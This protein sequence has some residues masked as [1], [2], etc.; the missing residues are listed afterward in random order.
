SDHY[1]VEV[2]D[3]GSGIPEE[4]KSKIFGKFSQADSSDTRKAGGTGLGLSIAKAIVEKHGGEIDFTSSPN[5]GTCFFFHLPHHKPHPL[6]EQ[7]NGDDCQFRILI[8]E[9]NRDISKLLELM[10]Q[11][12]G[13]CTDTAFTAAEAEQ[14]VISEHYDAMTL[15]LDLPDK[16]GLQLLQE[17]RSRAECCD[18]PII[19]VSANAHQ[20]ELEVNGELLGVVDWHNKPIDQ[21]RLSVELKLA[22]TNSSHHTN[23]ILHVEDDPDIRDVVAA[24]ISN[25][26]EVTPVETLSRAK[27]RVRSELYDLII[28]DL[29]L[30]DGAGEDLI[31]FTKETLN[32]E[33]PVIV[34]SASELSSEK[35]ED[36][37]AALVKSKT[38]NEQ[39]AAR[40]RKAIHSRNAN[41]LPPSTSTST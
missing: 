17:L 13:F 37:R 24:I 26:A 39:L 11:Q 3:H 9:D 31:P 32:H 22:I 21:A 6:S 1:L 33:T 20:G 18:L 30:P 29:S 40:I 38:S 27:E 19:V 7:E 12:D 15:D 23:R 10:L 4:F 8:C 16:S 41:T 25:L 5:H 2:S 36:V 14:K 35:L 28:L 34:F